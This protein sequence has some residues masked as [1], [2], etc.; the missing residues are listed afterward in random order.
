MSA[1]SQIVVEGVHHLYRPPSGRSVLALE[2]VSLTVR[3]REFLALL[4]PSGCGKSTLLYLIGGFL[5]IE[6]GKI[7]L[8]GQ[9]IAGPGPDRGIVFQHFALFPWKTVRANVLYGL[10]RMSLPREER[11]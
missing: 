11:E 7:L 4:G 6:T 2:D 3:A 10:E 9:P 5:P 8:E 1:T